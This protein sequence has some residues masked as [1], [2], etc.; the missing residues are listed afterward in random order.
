MARFVI[1]EHHA[2]RLHYDLRLERDG[3]LVSWAVPKTPPR[4]PGLRRLAIRVE[5]HPIGYIDFEGEIEEGRYGA[6]T[7]TIWDSG[8]YEAESWK[9]KKIVFHL[10]GNKLHGRYTF[11]KMVWGDEQWLLFKTRKEEKAS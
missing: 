5:D 10:H 4:R 2:R 6:G 3:V 1:Q 11:V 9:E 7:V 8:T